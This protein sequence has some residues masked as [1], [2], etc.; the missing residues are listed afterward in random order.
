MA[1]EVSVIITSYNYARF[2]RETIQSVLDQT[3]RDFEV[4]VVDDGSTDETAS[5]LDSFGHNITCIYQANQGKSAA[6]NRGLAASRGRYVAFLDSDDCWMPDALEARVVAFE[7]NPAVGVVYGR[8]RVVD[9]TGRVLPYAIGAPQRYAGD[10]FRS[11]LYGVFIP[12]LTFMVR[13]ECFERVG[14][15][16]DPSFGATN[17][18]EL[19]LRL[20][21]VCRFHFLDRPLAHYRVHGS[22]WSGKPAVMAEQMTRLLHKA[23]STPDLPP[24]VERTKHHVYRNL[25]SNAGLGYV[26]PG[27]RHLALHYFARALQVSPNP[28]WTAAR[29]A[30]LI[31]VSYLNRSPVGARIVSGIA[32]AKERVNY[33]RMG[34]E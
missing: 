22:N 18:W 13:R 12:F 21:R 14:M 17:D 16:F 34:P 23:L 28:L 32:S 11:L 24:E 30:Y 2:I 6:L 19:Y 27:P 5:I 8:A 15:Y 33:A 29:I 9:E 25:Y 10:T 7:A 1:A 31:A 20:S 3:Y 4:I 26:G